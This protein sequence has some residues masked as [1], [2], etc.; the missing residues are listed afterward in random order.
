MP[1][2]MYTFIESY[3]FDGK[4]VIPFTTHRGSGMGD[5]REETENLMPNANVKQ[6][7][8]VNGD[9]AAN[10]KDEILKKLE[11]VN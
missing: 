1:M 10:T 8:A 11:S 6:G 2:P 3:N 7:F 5:V 9:S 4:T